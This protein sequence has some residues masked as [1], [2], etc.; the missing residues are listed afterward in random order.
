VKFRKVVTGIPE[1]RVVMTHPDSAYQYFLLKQYI[2]PIRGHILREIIFLSKSQ[3]NWREELYRLK[4]NYLF[5]A[6]L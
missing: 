5:L 4:T 1:L 2:S 6:T 3:L